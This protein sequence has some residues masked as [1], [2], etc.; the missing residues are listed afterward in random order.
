MERAGNF[1][2]LIKASVRQPLP[3][4][5]K[6]IDSQLRQ[7]LPPTVYRPLVALGRVTWVI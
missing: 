1:V 7:A 2:F 3:V 6:I 5:W 4:V